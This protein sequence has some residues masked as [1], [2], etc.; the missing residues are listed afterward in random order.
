MT[1]RFLKAK[2]WQLFILTFGIPLIF[3]IV[4]MSTLFA[5]I[6]T[7][8]TP[9][10]TIIF[11]YMNFFPLIM[12]LF[13]AILF[14]WFWSVAIGLQKKVHLD[15]SMKV[16]KFKILLTLRENKQFFLSYFKYSY[17]SSSLTSSKSLSTLCVTR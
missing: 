12:L 17:N 1:E 14:G 16:K 15:I 3:Q 8:T 4:L 9:D 10:P 2:H 13:M 11:S 5:T 6:V 7:Q